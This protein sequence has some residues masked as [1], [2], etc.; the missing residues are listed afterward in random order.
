MVCTPANVAAPAAK[1]PAIYPIIGMILFSLGPARVFRAIFS[2]QPC[3]PHR[4]PRAIL[5]LEL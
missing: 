1:A 5:P 3:C 2:H 4:T